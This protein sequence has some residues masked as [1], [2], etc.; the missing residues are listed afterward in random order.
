MAKLA[1][2]KASTDVTVY[3]FIQDSSVT[4]GAGKT[5][6]AYNTS[7]LVAYYVRPLGSATQLT[8]ATQTVTG[9][10]SDGG[11]V[12]VDA[13]NMPGV[14]RL[15]LSDAICATGVNSVVV[16]LK[17]AANMAPVVLEIQLTSYDP[18]D[19]VRLG[20]TALPN[21]AADAA[22]GLPISDAGGLDL[23]AQIGTDIDSILADTGTDG[24]V[25]KSAGL[26]TDAVTEIQSGLA[27]EA[28]LTAIKGAGWMNET[29]KTLSDQIDCVDV[30]GV[31]DAVC[32][33]LLAG[34]VIPGSVGEALS[35][36]GSGSSASDIADAVLDELTAGHAVAGSFGKAIVDLPDDVYNLLSAIPAVSLAMPAAGTDL[37]A[38]AGD[39]LEIDITGLGNLSA[40]DEIYVTVKNRYDDDDDES[41]FQVSRDGGLLYL[42]GA[43]ASSSTD[44]SLTVIDAV[45]GHIQF[46][47]KATATI[48]IPIKHNIYDVKII[49][50]TAAESL[51]QGE[52]TF[53][54]VV[55]KATS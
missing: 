41:V 49:T 20:M 53:K 27:L 15:D 51:M 8:L 32:D 42:L 33:E 50:G 24:V 19:A 18:N 31:A 6:L 5:G 10:H 9:A 40:A 1:I 14:Y 48:L 21:A 43:A 25:L 11:F 28:T 37:V 47:L 39:T 35:T 52:I 55:T 45:T 44:G 16:M 34:H 46:T 38:Y 3:L 7:S 54:P 4:T 12:E 36:A 30:S 2:K 29:L 13:T 22:G 17:G 26:A 23:D